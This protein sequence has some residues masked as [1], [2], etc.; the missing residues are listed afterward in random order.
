M[1]KKYIVALKEEEREELRQITKKGKLKREHPKYT[2]SIITQEKV[3]I[4][5]ST[6]QA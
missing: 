4:E 3:A 2:L 5:I 1:K 6:S